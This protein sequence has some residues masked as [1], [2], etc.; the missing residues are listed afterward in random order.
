MSIMIG[1]F[2]L[3]K[4]SGMIVAVRAMEDLMAIR[5]GGVAEA[6]ITMTMA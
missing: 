3:T 1:V 6:L 5:D 2:A 4:M